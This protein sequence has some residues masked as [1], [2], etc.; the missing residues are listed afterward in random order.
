VQRAHA[1]FLLA[2]RWYLSHNRDELK[3]D[4]QWSGAGAARHAMERGAQRDANRPIMKKPRRRLVR[5][6]A[7]QFRSVLKSGRAAHAKQRV[8]VVRRRAATC[9][10]TAS[11]G[12]NAMRA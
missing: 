9:R 4:A 1:W 3:N 10:S 7:K 12:S 6:E 5:F 8:N 11:C 2:F